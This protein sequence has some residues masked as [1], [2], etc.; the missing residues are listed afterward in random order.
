[1]KKCPFCAEEIQDDAIKFRFC[2]ES[3]SR[4]DET[5]KIETDLNKE[6]IFKNTVILNIQA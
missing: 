3:L 4:K 6:D 1:M 2:G 5:D